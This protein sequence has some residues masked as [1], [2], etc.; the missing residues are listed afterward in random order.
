MARRWSAL[1]FALALFGL[2]SGPQAQTSQQAVKAGF[3]YRFA[4]FVT[5]PASAFANDQA[6]IVLCVLDNDPFASDLN[7]AVQNQHVDQHVFNVRRLADVEEAR[8]CQ[9]LYAVGGRADD[10]I[11]SVRGAPVLTVTDSAGSDARGVIHF[12]VIDN[13]VR[14]YADDVQ[15]AENHLA[16]SSRLLAL[17]VSVRRRAGA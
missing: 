14:F 13:R 11:R 15:A 17:A 2:A 9:V 16:I 8:Q 1:A 5:W 6:P 4:S 10:A 12:V 7:R 3:L